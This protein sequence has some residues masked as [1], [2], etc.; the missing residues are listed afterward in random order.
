MINLIA[1][2]LL[3]AFS[4]G[5]IK[6]QLAGLD[7]VA[8]AFARLLLA[9]AA[10]VP[11]LILRP[12]PRGAITPALGLGAI[13]FGL[14]YVLYLAAYQWLPA[15]KVALFT[16]FTPFF[17]LW[18]SDL[19]RGRIGWRALP[20]AALAVAG[21]LWV[22]WGDA[23]DLAHPGWTDLFGEQQWKGFLLLQGAN[24]CFAFGQV[25]FGGLVA[26]TGGRESG[27]LGWMYL[28]AAVATALAFALRGGADLQ[29]WTPAAWRAIL[30]LG[31]AP[32]ALGFYLWNRGAASC[33]PGRLAAANNLKIPL[34]VLV[35]WTVFGESAHYGR[36]LVGLA[37][38]VL[39]L[40]WAQERHAA[41][42]ALD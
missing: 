14:M 35:A 3:W 40:F 6:G 25:Y 22:Q 34:A 33:L 26:R 10:F 13:Q 5:L 16:V 41:E 1:A 8:V 37:A 17:V 27:L 11:A 21:A 36:A 20:P 2:S 19:R 4:F 30:Y 38:V 23:A 24:L 12:V 15:W 18:I 39:A 7:P 29:A 28:G 9:A 42:A 32:T 31:L